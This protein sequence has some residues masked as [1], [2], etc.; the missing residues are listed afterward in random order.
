M[1][2]F[3]V[4]SS[5]PVV[6]VKPGH[7]A[8]RSPSNIAIIKYWGKYGNQFPA[9][10]SI[11]MTL[12]HSFTETHLFYKQITDPSADQI[13]FYLD[14]QRHPDFE[15]RILSVFKSWR[16]YFPFIDQINIEIRSKN[17]FPH[18]AGIASSAS[19]MSA[20]ALCMVSLDQSLD[21]RFSDKDF[22]LK[23]SFI[24]RLGSGSA[25]R[26][27]FPCF[28]EWGRADHI[29]NSTDAYSIAIERFHPVFATL[30]DDIAIISGDPKEVS[31]T[32]GHSLMNDHPF[33]ESRF[34][35]A[36]KHAEEL[37]TVLRSGDINRFG[38]LAELESMTLHA[39]M[40][41]SSPSYTLILPNTLAAIKK[42]RAF[43]K[44]SHLPVYFTLDAGPNIHILY[45]DEIKDQLQGF[46]IDEIQPLTE[47]GIII[48]D[49]CGKGPVQ[50]N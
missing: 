9:N 13:T 34:A 49:I 23:A 2:E 30:H 14:N 39:L 44:E 28:A 22:F 5:H 43:R 8:W 16:E 45:P 37:M 29:Q 27:V 21:P 18:S 36:K 1:N 11:S 48:Q 31:S 38:E 40:M 35:Q 24:A 15:K 41:C 50:L 3:L 4:P 47:D 10:P 12:E 25:C 7:I 42:I 32:A 46:L 19:A 20:L 17:S 6:R 33:A 26:S